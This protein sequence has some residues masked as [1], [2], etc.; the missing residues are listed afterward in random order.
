MSTEMADVGDLRE[1][2]F[3]L[4][5]LGALH[6]AENA[7]REV[8]RE[9][10]DDLEVRHALGILAAQ[11]SRFE[12]ALSLITPVLRARQSASA[13]SDLGN[14][15]LGM[16]RFEDAIDSY[17]RAI[18]L[19]PALAPAHLNRGHALRNIARPAQ[20][21]SSYAA[22]CAAWPQLLEA[23]MS[24]GSLL[25]ERSRFEDALAAYD[26]AIAIRT[27]RADAHLGRGGALLGLG[28]P[29]EALRSS[30]TALELRADYADAHMACGLA[31]KAL[32]CPHAALESYDRAIAISPDYAEALFNRGNLLASLSQPER[33]ID[34][35][36][37]AVA[38]R[39]RFAAAH[40]NRGNV[41]RE[42]RQW[43]AALASY[44]R[45]IDAD[46]EHAEAYCN[47]ALV[48]RELNQHEAALA[49]YERAIALRP[50]AAAAHLGRGNLL[51]ELHRVH[52]AL[53]SYDAAL[54][55]Q[56]DPA[57]RAEI[58]F[59]RSHALL[60]GGDF[61]GGWRDF[62]SRWDNRWGRAMR[63]ARSFSEP[64]W[65]GE[66]P[67]A[68]RSILLHAEQGLG[69]TLQFCRF[70]K[71][72]SALGARVILEVQASLASLLASLQ[73]VD[74]LVVQ[75]DPLPPFDCHCP[76]LSL[77]LAM[78][79][80][81]RTIPAQIPYL[82]STEERLRY[83][84]Q[85]MGARERRRIGLVWS[86]GFR[87]DQPELRS[88][89]DRRN[90]PLAKLRSLRHPCLEF[91]SL[92][93][94]PSAQSE[95]AE[96]LARGWDGPEIRDCASELED[97]ADTAALI[98]QLDLVISVDTSAAHLAGALG[99]PVWILNRYDSCWRWLL[100]RSDSPWY[101]SAR[102]YRQEQPGDW[103]G[104]LRQVARD[105][106]RFAALVS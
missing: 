1:R 32:H 68:G 59:N 91:Y 50:G 77:P 95:L 101:P 49:S 76:L 2:G 71:S 3:T 96:L 85:R 45:A 22:A 41:H 23:H 39:P 57:E 56:A 61:E 6:E 86:G 12:E 34:S 92:Q 15:Y 38:S 17:D 105:L 43:E 31:L 7:Y 81:L 70:A 47:R 18:A 55:H 87:P 14:A 102:L 88:I 11:T 30:R 98:E 53:A 58:R 62:E 36:Q 10:P 83:W 20:A 29:E 99:K 51:Y 19:D 4:H 60:A 72:V 21:V 24:L 97:F 67:L 52:E 35:Y 84:R 100:D 40:F 104:V 79:T 78:K 46:G 64:L 69:D 27:D 82:R 16:S 26:Q 48:L 28:R 63:Q 13:W 90:I 8:L 74:H 66:M 42:L 89:N 65:R 106:D 73:G 33:A 75:G 37:R 103:D 80:T 54:A 44:A 9:R 25:L 93:K 94:G 5:E